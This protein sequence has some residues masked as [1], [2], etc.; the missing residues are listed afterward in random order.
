M[1]EELTLTATDSQ[2]G[3]TTT[4]L[5]AEHGPNKYSDLTEVCVDI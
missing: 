2:G 1:E 5:K 4:M 3:R